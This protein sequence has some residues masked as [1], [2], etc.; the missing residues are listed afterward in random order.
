MKLFFTTIDYT[1]SE[2]YFDE[3]QRNYPETTP[4]INIKYNKR[5]VTERRLCNFIKKYKM[6]VTINGVITFKS[7]FHSIQFF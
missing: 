7:Y 5:T 3:L 1:V 2:C 4:E 6:C